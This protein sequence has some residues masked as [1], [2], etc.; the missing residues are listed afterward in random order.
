MAAQA[1]LIVR[2][3]DFVILTVEWIGFEVRTGTGSAVP[4]LVA[5]GADPTVTLTFPPQAILEQTT[6]T[7]FSTASNV[8]SDSRLS[9]PS[10]LVF[11]VG[12]GAVIEL[13]A[14]GI[15]DALTRQ[16]QARVD[17]PS[18]LLE[19]PW[20]I[21][22]QFQ[23]KND[24]LV[25]SDHA[26]RPV[27]STRTGAVEL[28]AA[29]LR[30][31]DGGP[32]DARLTYKPTAFR[33]GPSIPAG[34]LFQQPPLDGWRDTI[35]ANSEGS[36][37]GVTRLELTSLG[38]AV[39]LSAKW[40]DESWTH[41]MALGRDNIVEC[42]AQGKL[43]PFGFPCVYLDFTRREFLPV[44][45]S[46]DVGCVAA[47]RKRR[48]LVISRPLL[49]GTR[50]RTFPFDTVEIL[51]DEFDLS[52]TPT[53]EPAINFLPGGASSPVRFPVRC[54]AG[55]TT[56]RFD[57]PLVFVADSQ[58]RPKQSVLDEWRPHGKVSIPGVAIDLI[59]DGGKPGDVQ[60]VHSLTFNGTTNGPE[61]RPDLAGFSVVLASLRTLLPGG[62]HE[63]PRPMKY[64]AGMREGSARASV[65]P[66]PLIFVPPDV[67]VSFTAHPERSG[68]L[69]APVFTAD[70]ISR[71]LGPV[72]TSALREESAPSASPGPG[73]FAGA[74]LFGFPLASLINT[75][76][77]PKPNPPKIVQRRV[78][79]EIITE[80]HWKALPLKAHNVF[81]P[82]DGRAPQ[83]D[84]FV[85]SR[86]QPAETT[87][88]A[89]EQ[90][91]PTC[92][93]KNFALVLPPPPAEKLL[94]LSFES[95]EFN[96]RP[97]QPAELALVTPTIGFHGPLTLLQKLQ[98]LL[99]PLLGTGLTNR[100]SN[101]GIAVGY[102][103][104][105]PTAA[106][107]AFVLR[108]V[109]A[110]FAVTV[111][112]EEKP[113]S[114]VL[115]FASREHPFAVSVT[116]FTGGGYATVEVAGA[117][118]PKVEICIEF[119]AML[120]VDFVVARAE[121]HA[122]GGVRFLRRSNG[123][124]ELEAFVRIGGSVRLLGLVTVSIELRVS[125]IFRDYPTPRLLGRA[126][127]VIE[128]DLTLYSGSVT[129]DSGTFEL[130]GGRAERAPETPELARD[131]SAAA[132]AAWEQYRKAFAP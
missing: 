78:G 67:P 2:G 90:P 132:F 14:Q 75:T 7:A 74:T 104:A 11:R 94:T 115:G 85:S 45:G 113:V 88:E 80:M 73:A 118:D 10:R 48:I 122:L 110:R 38:G 81:Q 1:Y 47:L 29:R 51:G 124:L 49:T 109:T 105:L 69:V 127:L 25:R 24:A 27:T 19:L 119:G 43:W 101:T 20:G 123:S 34:G 79:T 41:D 97:G 128:L 108:H 91:P 32:T 106:A 37:P 59:G 12:A 89:A 131:R 39:S 84:L 46:T 121:V 126:T 116:G 58:Q 17:G 53:P 98:D 16:G 31:S 76:A 33:K 70:G 22:A 23:G 26:S 55:D 8:H 129:I 95:A 4:R 40:R 117:G 50:A 86:S 36:P 102:E 114:V 96:Q 77:T 65:P 87:R 103:V 28:W 60:E 3:D 99:K 111:P 93:L 63:Q 71:E 52:G 66:V 54:R 44:Y 64:A 57:I 130:V 35:M 120:A 92:A 125:L 100:V 18:S 42:T 61:Y 15:L 21:F 5:T 9:Q 30:A 68:A 13:S 82:R 6:P 107:G 83:L 72:A 112:Y 56:V 62:D